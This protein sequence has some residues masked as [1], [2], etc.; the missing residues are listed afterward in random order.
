MATQWQRV[1][2]KETAEGGILPIKQ[3]LQSWTKLWNPETPYLYQVV[4]ETEGE[5]ITDR[6][7]L[8][9]VKRDGSV[10]YING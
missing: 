7:G 2:L 6:I 4:F 10:I 1:D 9:E 3:C 8:R 5:V